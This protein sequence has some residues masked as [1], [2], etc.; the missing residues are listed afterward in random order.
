MAI[1]DTMT[2]DEL[3][4]SAFAPIAIEDEP[5]HSEEDQDDSKQDTP[6]AE[7]IKIPDVVGTEDKDDD[8]ENS[9]DSTSSQP[10][11][12]SSFAKALF[13]E[14]VLP[15]LD[16]S[17]DKVESVEDLI[18]AMRKEI[19]VA[20][21][22]NLT[23]TQ[24][25]YL[26]AL[27]NGIP[28]EEIKQVQKGI[29]TLKSITKEELS[30]NEALRKELILADFKSKGYDEAKA[31]KL[32]QRSIDIG[33]DEND[34]LDA[35]NSL[36]EAQAQ[37]FQKSLQQKEL[38]RLAR[39]KESTDNLLKFKQLIEDTKEIIPGVKINNKIAEKI[40]EQA[41]KPVFKLPNGQMVNEV[42]KAQVENPM[43]FQMK[44]NYLFYITKGFTDFSKIATSQKTKATQE[45]DDLV[46]GNTFSPK[47][48]GL[49]GNMDY[50]PKELQGA[51]DD[52]VINNIV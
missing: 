18:Q 8:T 40:F 36:K 24:K 51:F 12:Y 42:V 7:E 46:K 20:K 32:T 31:L 22:A 2:F 49:N 17:Q 14:G 25:D 27:E 10:S 34:A 13:E 35:L 6:V 15:S 9:D 19:E 41:T 30:S 43:E 33:E 39:E 16:L 52:S 3:D 4:M 37:E 21:Y 11:P 28:E 47:A 1:E 29:D 26:K 38:D 50:T 44:V 48:S 23:P 45:L 5:E